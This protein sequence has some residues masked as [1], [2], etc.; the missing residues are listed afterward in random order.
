M[1]N[2]N[3][4]TKIVIVVSFEQVLWLDSELLVK[5]NVLNAAELQI[6]VKLSA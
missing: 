3:I 5:K 2:W 6:C 4:Q 1:E